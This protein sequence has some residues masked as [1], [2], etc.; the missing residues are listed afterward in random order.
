MEFKF[1]VT[2]QERKSLVGAI[3]EILNQPTHYNGAP[4]FSYKVGDYEIDKNGTV[5]GEWDLRLMVGL[6][7]RG[8][9]YEPSQTFHLITPRGTL[10]IQK[11]FLTAEDAQA[12]GYDMYFSHQGRGIFTKP[13]GTSE[14]G[15]HF[16]VVGEPYKQEEK[17]EAPAEEPTPETESDN[18]DGEVAPDGAEVTDISTDKDGGIDT[19][20]IEYP[21]EG[22]TPETL[23]NLTK[24]VQSKEVLIKTAL[25]ADELPIKMLDNRI[26][27]PWFKYTDSANLTAYAQFIT[28]LCQTAQ[29]KKRVIAKA[30]ESFE[31]PRFTMRV[32]LIGLGMVG[33]EFSTARKI[34]TKPLE[35][36]GAWRYGKPTPASEEVPANA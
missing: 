14:H 34:L 12:E 8:F 32:W 19:I 13:S 2:G 6:E 11:Q 25:G 28:A 17:P 20:T 26:A 22:F 10:L 30:Q 23:D 31:N 33:A 15:K 1:N 35:G 18:F 21:F 16:A 36:N 3:S 27:F 24:L 9:E 4:T 7:N 5:T 29:E